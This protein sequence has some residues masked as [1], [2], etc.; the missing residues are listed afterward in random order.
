MLIK[1]KI[2]M[3][4]CAFVLIAYNGTAQKVLGDQ[5][6]CPPSCPELSIS[7]Q[8]GNIYLGWLN[9][10]GSRQLSTEYEMVFEVTGG[11]N[12]SFSASGSFDWKDR[13][14]FITGSV[15]WKSKNNGGWNMIDNVSNYSFHDQTF[16]TNSEKKALFKLVPGTVFA[17]PDAQE[18]FYTFEATLE[19]SDTCH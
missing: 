8:S 4:L 18:G 17:A 16:I 19:I 2:V 11:Q 10:D 5:I 7:L 13:N 1:N 14:V 15:W 12:Q 3:L 9:P 6:L